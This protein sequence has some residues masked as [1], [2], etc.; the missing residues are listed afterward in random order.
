[1]VI[2]KNRPNHNSIS[3]GIN[4]SS[5]LS[6]LFAI[7]RTIFGLNEVA[8]RSIGDV[9]C[10]KGTPLSLIDTRV[11][12][13]PF[14]TDWRAYVLHCQKLTDIIQKLRVAIGKSIVKYCYSS[15]KIQRN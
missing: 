14:H 8:F 3:I 4:N 15:I 6:R 2:G 12:K 7:I 5:F 1:M 11:M 9:S 10:L 13:I